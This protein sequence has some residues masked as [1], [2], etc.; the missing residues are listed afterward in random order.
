[1]AL[2]RG[3]VGFLTMLIAFGGIGVVSYMM[4]S[5][6]AFLLEGSFTTSAMKPLWVAAWLGTAAATALLWTASLCPPK[7]LVAVVWRAR[8]LVA[9]VVG[10]FAWV[11]YVL[12]QAVKT[13]I[14]NLVDVVKRLT[15]HDPV[16]L[17]AK[18]PGRFKLMHIKDMKIGRAHV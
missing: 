9:I 17:I 3:C 12:I 4:S 16:A 11:Q 6:T 5:L 2:L 18:Y 14:A 10:L 8:A 15:S 13:M 7:V 1:M